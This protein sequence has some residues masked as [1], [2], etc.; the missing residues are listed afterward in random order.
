MIPR[1]V[2][3]HSAR[4]LFLLLLLLLLV[5][6]LLHHSPILSR[7]NWIGLQRVR[8]FGDRVERLADFQLCLEGFSFP[9]GKGA[10]GL[11]KRQE[12]CVMLASSIFQFGLILDAVS[13]LY[14]CLCYIVFLFD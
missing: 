4:L 12:F 13:I 3:G 14:L 10:V 1:M 5:F 11:C 8:T 7:S 2:N 6:L 9:M